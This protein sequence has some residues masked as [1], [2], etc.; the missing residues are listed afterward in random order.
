M[1]SD[2]LAVPAHSPTPALSFAIVDYPDGMGAD[3]KDVVNNYGLSFTHSTNPK[4]GD[5]HYMKLTCTV[6]A[7]DPI[8]GGTSYQTG[9][10]SLSASY[11]SF[12]FDASHKDALIQALLDALGVVTIT[13]LNQ[14]QS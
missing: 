5:R 7:T 13:K 3:R 9:V 6:T 4:T 1:L 12:G 2:P 10:V 8:T 11:P 14:F